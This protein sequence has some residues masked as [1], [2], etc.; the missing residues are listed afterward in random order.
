MKK[1]VLLIVTILIVT[2]CEKRK[3]EVVT[4][5][6]YYTVEELDKKFSNSDLYSEDFHKHFFEFVKQKHEVLKEVTRYYDNYDLYVDENGFVEKIR[7]VNKVPENI[8]LYPTNTKYYLNSEEQTN[9]LLKVL[10]D[11]KF[12]QGTVDNKPVKYVIKYKSGGVAGTGKASPEVSTS[13]SEF[14][15][16]EEVYFV[17]VD[18]QPEPIGGLET[19]QKNVTYPEIAKRAG[20]QGRVFVKAFIDENGNVI[21]TEI[22]KSAHQVLDSS[23]SN[24]VLKTKFI[25]GED[26]GKKVKTIV[27]VPIQFSVK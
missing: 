25:P 8:L 19:I 22:L 17:V 24:A 14:F 4:S 10:E 23:A 21:R 27:T 16:G 1:L 18:K 15:N 6:G 9:Y 2:S 7:P 3:I 13:G 12:P 26:K 5:E 11:Y 20:I